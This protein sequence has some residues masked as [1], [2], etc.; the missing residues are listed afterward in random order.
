MS[1]EALNPFS[2]S[3]GKIKPFG[4]GR[5]LRDGNGDEAAKQSESRGFKKDG[6]VRVKATSL[7]DVLS[8]FNPAR[9]SCARPPAGTTLFDTDLL[10]TDDV[11][12][13]KKSREAAVLYLFSCRN[14]LH[15]AVGHD[16]HMGTQ[17]LGILAFDVLFGIFQAL[18]YSF[19]QMTMAELSPPGLDSMV[20]FFLLLPKYSTCRN[21]RLRRVRSGS[22]WV[23]FPSIF[24]LCGYS[25]LTGARSSVLA[26]RRCRSRGWPVLGWYG[27][28]GVSTE[29]AVRGETVHETVQGH[30]RGCYGR[31]RRFRGTF[32][33]NP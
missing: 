3:D 21:A 8:L 28:R 26:R 24:A 16:R 15:L 32:P 33:T 20:H 17:R 2:R 14:H 9:T 5:I 10:G 6:S 23:V 11:A 31:C 12:D 18:Y 4:T 30:A 7:P 19:S 29:Q 13:L 22:N 25:A 1:Q 27:A